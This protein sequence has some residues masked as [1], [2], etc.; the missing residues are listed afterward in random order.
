ML[1]RVRRVVLQ[2]PGLYRIQKEAG[3]ELAQLVPIIS[4]YLAANLG[5][6]ILVHSPTPFLPSI[7]PISRPLKR[8]KCHPSA[9]TGGSTIFG[10]GELAWGGGSSEDLFR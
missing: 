2:D 7:P 9:L 6:S 5:A 8:D 10:H 3:R 4:F 1:A